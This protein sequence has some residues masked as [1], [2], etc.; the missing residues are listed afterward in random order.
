VCVCVCVRL[1][2]PVCLL[3]KFPGFMLSQ[4]RKFC[5]WL[6]YC[7]LYWKKNITLTVYLWWSCDFHY[8][9]LMVDITSGML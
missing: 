6:C 7:C 2:P 3:Y 8:T 4:C 9:K 1:L 5:Q